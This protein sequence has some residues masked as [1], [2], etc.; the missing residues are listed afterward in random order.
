MTTDNQHRL[1]LVEW[2]T[3]VAVLNSRMDLIRAICAHQ[4]V[5]EG[6]YEDLG[7]ASYYSGQ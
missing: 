4:I 2:V 6:A 3:F 7:D 5:G 1:H